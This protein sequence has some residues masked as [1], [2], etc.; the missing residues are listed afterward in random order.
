MRSQTHGIIV[1]PGA[2]A[3]CVVWIRPDPGPEPE[4]DRLARP[5][6]RGGRERPEWY[7]HF[8]RLVLI[9]HQARNAAGEAGRDED[10]AIL[11]KFTRRVESRPNIIRIFQ[12]EPQVQIA[13]CGE[14]ARH[15]RRSAR[16]LPDQLPLVAA[17]EVDAGAVLLL[18]IGLG[19]RGCVEEE[20]WRVLRSSSP[21]QVHVL[22]RG[23]G[24]P[25]TPVPNRSQHECGEKQSE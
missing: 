17:S 7:C 23:L 5:I 20:R 1:R 13:E 19:R 24:R 6:E 15:D 25:G 2:A 8:L 4:R 16:P 11:Q 12:R 9:D 22:G 10:G 3:L 14:R 18:R 21:M